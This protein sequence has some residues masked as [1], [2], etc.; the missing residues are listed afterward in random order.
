MVLLALGMATSQDG[1]QRAFNGAIAN[2]LSFCNVV[3]HTLAIKSLQARPGTDVLT[4]IA[5]PCALSSRLAVDQ[6]TAWDEL[7]AAP[8]AMCVCRHFSASRWRTAPCC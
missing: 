3:F 4:E 5:E 6:L 1:L 7:T 2:S 8:H